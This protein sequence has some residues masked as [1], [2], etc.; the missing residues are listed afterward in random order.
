MNVSTPEGWSAEV[1]PAEIGNLPEG[2]YRTV[3]VRVAPHANIV[4]SEYQIKVGV[5]SDQTGRED[6]FRVVVGEGPMLPIL[7]LL[8]IAAIVGGVLMTPRRHRRR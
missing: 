7:G 4:A 8:V 1:V 5:E 2:E 3:E 6:E